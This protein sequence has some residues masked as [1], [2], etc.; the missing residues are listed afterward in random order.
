M[1]EINRS[2]LYH[3]AGHAIIARRL[4]I[5]IKKIV[6]GHNKKENRDGY[7]ETV[8]SLDP[9]EILIS[10]ASRC[11]MNS[12]LNEARRSVAGYASELV[13]APKRAKKDLSATDF[14]K[15]EMYRAKALLSRP[16]YV[17]RKKVPEVKV[18][19]EEVK[20][21]LCEP[22]T[23]AELFKLARALVRRREMTGEEIEKLLR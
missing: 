12:F 4:G 20:E 18:I 9:M 7:V 6:I 2:V 19:L 11:C 5:K 14:E 8:L 15:A 21:M 1:N 3:E 10:I 16:I 13:F 22:K 17:H 23:R